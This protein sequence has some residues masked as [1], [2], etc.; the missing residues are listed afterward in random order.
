VLPAT[1]AN[2]GSIS[3]AGIAL[4]LL[5]IGAVTLRLTTRPHR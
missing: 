4:T 5:L 3:L 1:G 2:D